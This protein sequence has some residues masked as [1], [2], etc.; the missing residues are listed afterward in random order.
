M[1]ADFYKTFKK[2]DGKKTIPKSVVSVI[3]EQ[4]PKGYKYVKRKDGN[5]SVEVDLRNTIS[6]FRL[7]INRKKNGIPESVPHNRIPEYCYRTQKT[8][9]CENLRT[10]D[11]EQEYK[12]EDYLVDPITGENDSGQLKILIIPDPFP[13]PV[14]L[15]FGDGGELS[16]D[17]EFERVPFEDMDRIKLRNK[18][19]LALDIV[20]ILSEKAPRKGDCSITI[21]MNHENA[22]DVVEMIKGL[23]IQ[24]A[25]VNNNLTINGKKLVVSTNNP[26]DTSGLDAQI[27]F[28]TSLQRLQGIL[29]VRFDP[30]ADY[31]DEDQEFLRELFLF[32]LE[33]GEI[34]MNHPFSHF[35]LANDNPT[36]LTDMVGKKL[37]PLIFY[38]EEKGQL[39]GAEFD[40]YQIM[41]LINYSIDSVAV[42]SDGKGAELYISDSDGKEVK[43]IKRY[44]ASEKDAKEG[45]GLLINKYANSN[46]EVQG[47][48][49]T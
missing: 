15:I 49:T 27:G 25:F 13:P 20:L 35:H 17:L 16:L 23:E 7:D 30:T 48:M 21:T 14:T 12:A 44:Y 9:E 28:W 22:H 33:D 10:V 34:V 26:E 11:G 45:T 40:L 18:T 29:N 19:F 38:E 32:F 47:S 6:Q 39:L 36:S 1:I 24:K 31:P 42:D 5:Y 8:L 4:L 46:S 41:I 43:L 37:L 2:K 3:N